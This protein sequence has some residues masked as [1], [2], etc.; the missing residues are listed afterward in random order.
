MQ[1]HTC[2]VETAILECRFI[3]E[4]GKHCMST[5]PL[6]TDAGELRTSG[7]KLAQ[8]AFS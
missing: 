1:K 3:G 5:G 6:L 2:N 4:E 7:C 8:D